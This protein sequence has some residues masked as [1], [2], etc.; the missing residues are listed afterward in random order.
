ME[1]MAACE[2]FAEEVVMIPVDVSG[3]SEESGRE[4]L[5]ALRKA[6]VGRRRMWVEEERGGAGMSGGVGCNRGAPPF[7]VADHNFKKESV[8][9]YAP[10][11]G[12]GMRWSGNRTRTHW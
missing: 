4:A 6:V 10:R 1:R 12:R 11:E 8:N 7:A 2:R 3:V 9:V 5:E